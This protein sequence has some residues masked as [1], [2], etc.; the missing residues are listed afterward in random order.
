ME[1]LEEDLGATVRIVLA[2]VAAG[3][4]QAPSGPARRLVLRLQGA[5]SAL[6]ALAEASTGTKAAAAVPGADGEPAS[7]EL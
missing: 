1:P 3:Q 7:V 6:D 4:L 5:L 2:Q